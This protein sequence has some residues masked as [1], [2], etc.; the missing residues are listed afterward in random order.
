MVALLWVGGNLLIHGDASGLTLGI[1]IAFQRYIQKMVWPMA[2]LGMALSTY[3]RAVTSSGRLSEILN[4]KTD[5][6][7]RLLGFLFRKMPKAL[8]RQA[9]G[10][11][12]VRCRFGI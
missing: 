12:Q 5:V 1:F 2:A 3:Q 11:L 8:K 4:E 9:V 7:D 6:P 10:K